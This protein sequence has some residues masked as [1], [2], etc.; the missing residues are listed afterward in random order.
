MLEKKSIAIC[1]I[2]MVL[3]ML[4]LNNTAN[5]ATYKVGDATGWTFNVA[6]WE[7]GKNFKADDVLVFNYKP[8]YHNVVVVDENGYCNCTAPFGAKVYHS[9]EDQIKLVKGQNYFICSFPGHC[10][11]GLRIAIDAA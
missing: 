3:G 5:A 9:G 11:K 1:G 10:N 4:V 2:T 8:E 6:G 7:N